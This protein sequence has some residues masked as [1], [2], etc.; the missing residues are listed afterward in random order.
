M[1]TDL[2]SFCD[3]GSFAA[4]FLRFFLVSLSALISSQIFC[5]RARTDS[6]G[7]P[8]GTEVAL[9]T[10]WSDRAELDATEGAAAS[11]E[12][13]AAAGRFI[14]AFA[15]GVAIGFGAGR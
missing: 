7:Q 14:T 13:A 6:L 4:V 5:W 11:P 9:G 15:F 12:D 1:P 8:S 2:Y 10:G 3:L